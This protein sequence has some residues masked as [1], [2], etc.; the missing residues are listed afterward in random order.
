MMNT[1]AKW[2][3]EAQI[4]HEKYRKRGNKVKNKAKR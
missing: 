2:L 4:M 1:V 3:F